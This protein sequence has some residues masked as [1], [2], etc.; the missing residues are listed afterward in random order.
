MKSKT[1]FHGSNG[2]K[3][4]DIVLASLIVINGSFLKSK[5]WDQMPNFIV[6]MALS[7]LALFSQASLGSMAVA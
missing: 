7:T 5:S 4:I 1:Q 6:Q 2:F 3:Y